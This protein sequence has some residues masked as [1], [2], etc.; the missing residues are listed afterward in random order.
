[1]STPNKLP[2]ITLATTEQVKQAVSEA[3]KEFREQ[4]TYLTAKR[5]AVDLD[6]SESFVLKAK[7]DGLLQ[8]YQPTKGGIVRFTR[9]H[10]QDFMRRR[11][12]NN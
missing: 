9:Q 12:G 5:A 8:C 7:N 4:P 11:N 6:V 2:Q 1:M 10:L 3:M